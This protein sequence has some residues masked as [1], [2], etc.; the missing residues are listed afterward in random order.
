[1]DFVLTLLVILHYKTSDSIVKIVDN[2]VV[3]FNRI[4][5]DELHVRIFEFFYINREIGFNRNSLRLQTTL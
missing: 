3:H 1:M 2:I 4:F 5:D